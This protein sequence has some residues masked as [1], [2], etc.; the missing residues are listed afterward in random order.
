M[1]RQGLAFNGNKASRIVLGRLYATQSLVA[2]LWCFCAF[3]CT[4]CV[5]T[6]FAVGPVLDMDSSVVS[7]TVWMSHASFVFIGGSAFASSTWIMLHQP[8]T[9]DL[10]T[11]FYPASVEVGE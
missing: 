4:L 10:L 3:F 1:G 5:A 2:F 7:L 6:G 9:L 11:C 8:K